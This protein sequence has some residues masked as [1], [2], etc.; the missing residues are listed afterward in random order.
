M[1]EA[2]SSRPAWHWY[3][4]W[5]VVGAIWPW[6]VLGIFS[7][8]I[9]VLPIAAVATVVLAARAE[10]RRGAAGIVSGLGLPLL[11]IAAIN[12]AGPGM[13]CT[14]R[15]TA[16]GY[17]ESCGE[18]WNPLPWLALGVVFLVVGLALQLLRPRDLSRSR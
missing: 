16:G 15:T 5:L 7:I 17:V 13:I 12:R 1:P 6:T 18:Q 9:F 2:M 8:G 14:T 4:A 3:V 10:S 11:F